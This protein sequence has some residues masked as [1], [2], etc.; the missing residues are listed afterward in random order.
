MATESKR[1]KSEAGAEG[2]LPESAEALLSTDVTSGLIRLPAGVELNE[3]Q[4]KQMAAEKPVRLIVLAG[5]IDCGKT[6]LLSILYEMFQGGP[7]KRNSLLA[8][9]PFPLSRKNVI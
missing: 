7:Y 9:I 6:T 8:V 5:A 2:D 1:S 4:A 3:D